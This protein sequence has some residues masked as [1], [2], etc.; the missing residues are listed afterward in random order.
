MCGAPGELS[1]EAHEKRVA[2]VKRWLG[3]CLHGSNPE[4]KMAA[5]VGGTDIGK[6]QAVDLIGNLMGNQLAWLGA[7]PQLL[8][9]G[10]GDRHDSDEY[11]LAGKRMVVVNELEVHQTLDEGQVLRFVGPEGATVSLRRMRQDREDH[12]VTWK[13]T[14][15]TNELPR[16][17]L[18]PQI[19]GRLVVFPLSEVPVPDEE[20][21]DIQAA[22]LEH[23]AQAVLAHL[24]KEWRAW[25]VEK[26]VNLAPTGLIVS[27][28]MAQA[29]ETYKTSNLPIELE[30]IEECAEK[31]EGIPMTPA[32]EFWSRFQQWIKQE[33]P[34]VKRE[35]WPGRNAFYASLRTLHGRDGIEVVME[36]KGGGRMQFRGLRG[37]RLLPPSLADMNRQYGAF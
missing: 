27:E 34:S 17:R 9:Q 29:K 28:D 8:I 37:I 24:V 21:Y 10:K 6:N 15:T 23:E 12:W 26:K 4:K 22:V 36:N 7:R 30:F 18:T 19:E 2:A 31:G 3:Y 13:M 5:F 33:H 16:T 35:D 25:Y 20:K 32:S 1:P 14:V 11:G